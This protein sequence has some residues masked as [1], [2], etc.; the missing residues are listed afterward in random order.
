LPPGKPP[1][2]PSWYA[3]FY[4]IIAK[5]G[6]FDVVIGNPPYVEYKGTGSRERGTGYAIKGYATEK[7]GNLYAFVVE[8]ALAL[9]NKD[10]TCGM[11]V[12]ISLGA[13]PRMESLRSLIENNNKSIFYSNFSDR[14]SALFLGVHQYLS[15][16]LLINSQEKQLF[17]TVF[18]HWYAEERDYIFS[19]FGYYNSTN[20]IKDKTW[21]KF[22]DTLLLSIYEKILKDKTCLINYFIEKGELVTISGGTGG[23]W[24]RAFDERQ[25]SNEYKNKFVKGNTMSFCAFF[26]STLFYII[27]RIYSD[28]RHLTD[29]STNKINID[30]DANLLSSLKEVSSKHLTALKATKE[31]R[32]GKMTYEQYRPSNAKLFVDEIDKALAKHYGFTDEELDFIINYDIKYR[33]GAELEGEENA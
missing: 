20:F 27:W 4:Q 24:L 2:S 21:G 23:Y 29:S 12:P 5:R 15:I 30:F 26:N 1:T 6:G 8:R 16:A 7:C 3:E 13:T 31:I 14:P 19:N 18:K 25:K 17:S 33:M 22:G 9:S 11:I 28:C 10:A 32:E